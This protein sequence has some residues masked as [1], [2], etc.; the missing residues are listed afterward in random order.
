MDCHELP[1]F[2]RG[3][4]QTGAVW[5]E[6][7]KAAWGDRDTI[8]Q[9]IPEFPPGV[10]IVHSLGVVPEFVSLTHLAGGTEQ[11]SLYLTGRT[12][13]GMLVFAE[14]GTSGIFAHWFAMG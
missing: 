3:S 8:A 4:L 14:A 10:E 6:R 1:P 12:T 13:T 5:T 9:A 2:G 7:L 11:G